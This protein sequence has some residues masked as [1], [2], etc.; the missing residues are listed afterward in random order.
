M[1]KETVMAKF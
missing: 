1:Y